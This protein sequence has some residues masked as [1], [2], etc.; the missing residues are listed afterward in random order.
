M[1]KKNDRLVYAATDLVNFLACPSVTSYDLVDMET[2]LIKAKDDEQ[3]KILQQKGYEHEQAYLDLLKSRYLSIVDIAAATASPQEARQRTLAAMKAGADIIFQGFLGDSKRE[4]HIDFLRKVS[5]PSNLGDFSYEA[6]D[7]KLARSAKPKHIIQL[8]FYSDLVSQV[9][10]TAPKQIHLVFGDKSERSFLYKDFSAY[11]QTVHDRFL[12]FLAQP[13]HEPE[14]CEYCDYCDW[15]EHC[16]EKW[17]R[18]DSLFQVANIRRDQIKKLR[19]AGIT[20]VRQLGEASPATRIPKLAATTYRTLRRQAAL[21]LKK[22]MTGQDC[23]ELLP[24]DREK[25]YGFY[26]LPPPAAG[27]LFFD[28]EGDPLEDDGLEYLFGVYTLEKDIPVFRDF[29]AHNRQQE[30]KA[31]E[32]FIDFVTA[33]LKKYPHAH[34]YHYAQ[35][36][37]TALKRL[38]SLH[39]TREVEVDNLLR[40][41]RLVDLYKV[42]REGIRV[43]EPSYSIKNLETFYMDKRQGEVVSAVGSV[44]YYEKWKATQDQALLESIRAYNEEDCR[45][46]Y[47]LRQWL[48][49][50]M[51]PEIKGEVEGAGADDETQATSKNIDQVSEYEAMLQQAVDSLTIDLPGDQLA[52]SEN[53]HLRQ[54]TAH[55]LDFYRR[56]DK[57][58]WWSL[59]SRRET[60]AEDL[61]E[62]PECLSGLTRIPG[63]PP[64]PKGRAWLCT[65]SFPDQEYKLLAGKSCTGI[66]NGE[67]I[68]IIE[69]IDALHNRIILKVSDRHHPLPEPLAIG[70][71]TPIYTGVLR[72]ALFRFADSA[73]KDDGRY[74]AVKNLLQKA[75]PSIRG[76]V[77]GSPIISPGGELLS[78][79]IQTVSN[80]NGSY[81]TIQGPPGSGKT[82]TAS[83]IIIALLAAGRKVGVSSNSH[84]AINN[85]LAGV[86]ACAIGKGVRFKG[87][88]KVNR[89]SPDSYLHSQIIE[90]VEKNEEMH[91]NLVGATAWFFARP[92][93]D[94]AFDYLFIDEAGQVSLA[95]LI[96]M[97]LAA[98]NIVLLGDQMQL[99]QPI[100]GVHPGDSGKSVLEFL[101]E[102]HATIPEDRGIFLPD[103]YRMHPE[104]CKFI[105]DVVYDS[106]LSAVTGNEN[107][108]LILRP[109]C[110]PLLRSTGLRFLPINHEGCSQSSE[111]EAELIRQ[112]VDSLLQQ[113]YQDRKGQRHSVTLDNILIVAPYNMQVNLL[114]RTLPEG[115]RVGTVDKFQGQEAEVVIISMTTSDGD[116][117]P[118]YL[119]F[120]YSKQRLNV[121]ISRARCLA[122]LVAN[123]NLLKIQC[124]TVEQM[125]LVN[126]LCCAY[127]VGL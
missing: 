118:R 50:I 82:Y 14:P 108:K 98:K 97:G 36:E 117:L 18:E 58:G 95:H 107:Q 38:M 52:W 122:L 8:C 57:P 35:Y 96:S 72:D 89:Q 7:T 114:Q 124:H 29:W 62:D 21:Q 28:M 39:G 110:H 94:Q 68:G 16:K 1:Q 112:L 25:R 37:E 61:I 11:Y 103:T 106:R 53:D 4:G 30:K 73:V 67:Q 27:D 120:L 9:Q 26:R 48:L 77:P 115:S 32:S 126:T 10:G 13:I 83:H 56:A 81:L 65:Y 93:N 3:A 79:A 92:E 23:Y 71:P 90:D 15:R 99:G 78:E 19:D 121:A 17:E 74:T 80:L 123:P 60:P 116:C 55:L 104:L 88:K 127:Y 31:F 111:E 76:V 43:S 109:D 113:S 47:L 64:C 75:I 41:Q 22:R 100:Q 24:L 102:D 51:P 34:I 6:A 66:H 5:R 2:P 69:E 86:E 85:L 40:Q 70:P 91:G 84:K 87:S 45:S 12:E 20:T 101:M 59:F 46:T 49:E 44:V 54:R 63:K 119:D 42:V 105:S 125:A 33:H